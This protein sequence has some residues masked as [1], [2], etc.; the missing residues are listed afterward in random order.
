[1]KPKLDLKSG[2]P[3]L[4]KI[5]IKFLKQEKDDKPESASEGISHTPLLLL[6]YQQYLFA[7]SKTEKES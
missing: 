4:F 2:F 7:A 6:A 5:H 1:M 3:N